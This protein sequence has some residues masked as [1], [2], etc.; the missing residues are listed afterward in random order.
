MKKTANRYALME[1]RCTRNRHTTHVAVTVNAVCWTGRS[2]GFHR[3][4]VFVVLLALPTDGSAV[5]SLQRALANSNAR[6]CRTYATIITQADSSHIIRQ[7]PWKE[8]G[9]ESRARGGLWLLFFFA[10]AMQNVYSGSFWLTIGTFLAT[11]PS[12]A[13]LTG[14]IS[15]QGESYCTGQ[16]IW[17]YSLVKFPQSWY[18]RFRPRQRN[19]I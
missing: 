1:L 19:N 5:C 2:G 11:L 7:R 10:T 6:T 18:S 13:K 17:K 3:T 8:F 4:D 9:I 15:W 12:I 14:S 16:R